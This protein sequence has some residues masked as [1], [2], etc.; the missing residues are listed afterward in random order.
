MLEFYQILGLAKSDVP[1][2]KSNLPTLSHL[3][4]LMCF[5]G[6]FGSIKTHEVE[7]PSKHMRFLG[8]PKHMRFQKGKHKNG[9]IKAHE[10]SE[11]ETQKMGPSKH[12]RF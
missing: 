1:F 2:T 10:V 3:L 8:P 6:P 12:M 9:S 11:G 5:D 4:A 7:V